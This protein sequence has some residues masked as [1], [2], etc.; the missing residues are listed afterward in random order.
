MSCFLKSSHETND[1]SK[2]ISGRP[3]CFCSF[4][5]IF[6]QYKTGIVLSQT[7]P[8]PQT[9]VKVE[10]LVDNVIAVSPPVQLCLRPSARALAAPSV[11][12]RADVDERKT[13]LE[14]VPISKIS[15]SRGAN[16][17]YKLNCNGKAMMYRANHVMPR[18]LPLT[19]GIW[20]PRPSGE[21]QKKLIYEAAQNDLF[22][23]FRC[24]KHL[25]YK[26]NCYLDEEVFSLHVLN[27]IES[28][29]FYI[30]VETL[31]FNIDMVG[32][33]TQYEYC[34]TWTPDSRGQVCD[35]RR[36]SKW[37]MKWS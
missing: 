8:H 1:S 34:R 30:Y 14:I 6:R 9:E 11:L 33:F 21:I 2:L 31:C 32:R 20:S 18:G 10:R 37:E 13:S 23:S 26:I 7:P 25:D 3:L 12:P 17:K 27:A 35:F 15:N 22:A 16:Q 28:S 5:T 29:S 19:S 4:R 36:C 24:Q